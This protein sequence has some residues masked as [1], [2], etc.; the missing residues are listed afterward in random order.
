MKRLTTNN[1]SS[2]IPPQQAV[3]GGAPWKA[4]AHVLWSINVRVN[5]N[6]E[7]IKRRYGWS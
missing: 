3:N 4:V 7:R 1:R 6:I 5:N 2:L